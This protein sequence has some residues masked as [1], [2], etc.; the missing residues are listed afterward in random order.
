[1]YQFF[2]DKTVKLWY[3][4]IQCFLGRNKM[5]YTI[6]RD[7]LF[8][9]SV[10]IPSKIIESVIKIASKQSLQI[11][12]WVFGHPQNE[13]DISVISHELNINIDDCEDSLSF[14]AEKGVLI[15]DEVRAEEH[16]EEVKQEKPKSKSGIICRHNRHHFMRDEIVSLSENKKE[17]GDLIEFGQQLLGKAFTNADLDSLAALYD[18][19]NLSIHFIMTAMEYSVSIGKKSMGY[20]ESIC[21]AWINSGVNDDN[22]DVHSDILRRQN[23]YEETIKNE[24]GIYRA[25]SAKEREFVENW[26]EVLHS[27]LELMKLAYDQCIDATGKTS[28]SYINK[29]LVS[30]HQK[31]INSVAKAKEELN[32]YKKTTDEKKTVDKL[33]GY[34]DLAKEYE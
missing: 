32:N 17:F 3:H 13:Y 15:C 14:L 28:F 6:N 21:V 8:G 25:F 31:N 20:V 19:Y 30:W 24:F 27:P 1:M 26:F 18:F 7:I 33:Q 4:I 16:A 34:I 10:S 9:T 22:I 11:L 29:I 2:M 23:K 5:K 12:L